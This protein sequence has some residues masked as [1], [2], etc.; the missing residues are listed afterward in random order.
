MGHYDQH[1]DPNLCPDYAEKEFP[2]AKF[3]SVAS[4]SRLL[5]F[6]ADKAYRL[7]RLHATPTTI[8]SGTLIVD[9]LINGATVLTTKA[10]STAA[11][12]GTAAT[13]ADTVRIPAGAT[14]LVVTTSDSFTVTD[15]LG[16][17]VL[18]PLL[19]FEAIP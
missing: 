16:L 3:G 14:V 8:A 13:F 6:V 12:A 10:T 18:R 15:V 19:G 5:R 17:L 4:S 11:D 7:V 9:L 2:I 1:L